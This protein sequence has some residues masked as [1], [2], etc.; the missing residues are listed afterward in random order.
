[1]N[2]SVYYVA[3]RT[4]WDL[5][6]ATDEQDARTKGHAALHAQYADLRERLGREVP[7]EL[8]TVRLAAPSEIE[9]WGWHQQN[10]ARES[11]R[12]DWPLQVGDSVVFQFHEYRVLDAGS[13]D[14]QAVLHSLLDPNE[15]VLCDAREFE[16]PNTR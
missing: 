6:Q 3:T 10:V 13:D 15:L 12:R 8:R 1:M 16:I 2:T 7:V 5:V 9:Q 4:R 11:G 14:R